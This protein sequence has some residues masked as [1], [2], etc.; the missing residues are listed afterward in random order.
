MTANATALRNRL[1]SRARFRNLLVFVKTAELGSLR[2]AAEAAAMAQPSASQSLSELESL[3]QCKLFLRHSRGMALTAVGRAL[4][5]LARRLL[6]LVDE[7]ADRVAAL[8]GSSSGM[9]RVG[10]IA[11]AVHGILLKALPSF[12]QKNSDVVVHLEEMDGKRQLALIADAEVDLCLCRHPGTLPAGWSYEPLVSD[13]FTIV[14]GPRHPHSGGRL[15]PLDQLAAETWLTVPVPLAARRALDQLFES[16]PQ[17]PKMHGVVGSVPALITELLKAERLLALMPRRLVQREIET[18][19]L[20]EISIPIDLPLLEI[21]MML[22]GAK[23]DPALQKL[24]AFL[25]KFTAAGR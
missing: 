4:L 3:L 22:P 11:A 20:A 12:S 13:R 7:S 5:P 9:V 21:G 10:A 16:A 14:C 24:S 23:P 25:R 8:Q 6:D 2:L 17:F 1:I 15:I 19:E 18:G